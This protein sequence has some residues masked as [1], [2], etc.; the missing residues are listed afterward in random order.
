[1]EWV[2]ELSGEEHVEYM[3]MMNKACTNEK[4]R[5]RDKF[6][7]EYMGMPGSFRNLSVD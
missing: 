3:K 1:M 4:L 2:D 6:N 7:Q 5:R